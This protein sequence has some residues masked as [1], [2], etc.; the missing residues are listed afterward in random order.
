MSEKPPIIVV[1]DLI[2][3]FGGLAATDGLTLEIATGETHALIGPNGAGKTTLIAQLQGELSPDSGEIRFQGRDITRDPPHRRAALGIARSFQITSVFPD[4]TA[5]ENV[6]FAVQA[7][8][9]HGFRFW[10]QSRSDPALL[11][12]A[13]E[14]LD[15]IGLS[16]RAGRLA[17]DLSHGERRQLE[18][19]MALAM[20]PSLLLLD[21]PMAGMGRAEG[22]RMTRIL[23]SLK[24]TYSMLLVEHDM[25]AVFALAD[26]VSVLVAGRCLA[27]GA[28]AEIRENE[29]VREAYLGKRH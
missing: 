22:V 14:A 12:P 27:T 6:A 20:R 9:G 11:R 23:E 24:R 28:P 29:A 16:H 18:L 3:R 10:R 21:E 5:L 26:R 19:A 17:R 13:W 7:Q 25:D 8:D 2:K 1:T 4:F 15:T